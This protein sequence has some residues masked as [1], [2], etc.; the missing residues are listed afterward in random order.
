[1]PGQFAPTKFR[2]IFANLGDFLVSLDWVSCSSKRK[3]NLDGFYLANY[4]CENGFNFSL[5]PLSFFI[6]EFGGGM[7][8]GLVADP[9]FVAVA[10]VG[11]AFGVW[12]ADDFGAVL[13]V[14]FNVGFVCGIAGAGRAG[15]G[16]TRGAARRVV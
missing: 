9:A 12:V 1:M 3:H 5:M 6:F 16:R 7:E 10:N 11:F 4:I 14:A 8:V 2:V 15:F 13:T